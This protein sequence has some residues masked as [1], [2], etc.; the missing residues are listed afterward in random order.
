MNLREK[1]AI[2][3][4]LLFIWGDP[5]SLKEI[6]KILEINQKEAIK[7]IEEMREEFDN[8]RG[9]QIIK[10]ENS[11][12]LGTREEHYEYIKK[13]K[14]SKKIDNISSAAMETLSIIAYNQPITKLEIE[15]IRGV[16]CDKALQTLL[17]KNMI[18]E[19]GRLEKTGKPII[20]KTTD[21]FLRAFGFHSLKELP[22]LEND[23]NIEDYDIEI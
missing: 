4:A 2:I 17:E 6:E 16:K 20:Y 8:T 5:L 3:E 19:A 14:N 15:D 7:I 21:E 9:L 18:K 11:Y 1:K 22:L 10:I 13:L 12:Q 23:E